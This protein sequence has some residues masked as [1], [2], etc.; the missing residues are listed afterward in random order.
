MLARILSIIEKGIDSGVADFIVGLAMLLV[1]IISVICAFLVFFHQ[2]NRSKKD[3]ACRLAAH[4][5]DCLLGEN[6]FVTNVYNAAQILDYVKHTFDKTEKLKDFDIFELKRILAEKKIDLDEV[7]KRLYNIDSE[8]ILNYSILHHESLSGGER[9]YAGFVVKDEDTGERKIRDEHILQEHFKQSVYD[10]LNHLE[11]FSMNCRYGLA[12]E[13][14]LYQSLHQTFLSSVWMLYPIICM[15]NTNNENKM[16]TN[17][18]WL[19]KKWNHRLHRI[20]GKAD[21]KRKTLKKIADLFEKS[22][23]SIRAKEFS[24]KQLK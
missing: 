2:K 1:T 22:A 3:A 9:A 11:W 8:I 17:V 4:Y 14:L 18:I 15:N 21:F 19:F 7:K 16:C 24:G 5:A 13:A 6:R 10:L 23:N 12:D 20:K